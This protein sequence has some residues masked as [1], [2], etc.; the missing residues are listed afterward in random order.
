MQ[1]FILVNPARRC[2]D[3][4]PAHGQSPFLMNVTAYNYLGV[5]DIRCS[6]VRLDDS[7]GHRTTASVSM[8]VE[9][10][11]TDL[12]SFCNINAANDPSPAPTRMAR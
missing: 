7:L 4:I 10:R 2:V 5:R 11:D 9:Y 1:L 3:P 8:M 12:I 6:P